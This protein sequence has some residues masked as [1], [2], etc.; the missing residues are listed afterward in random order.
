MF[1]WKWDQGHDIQ[2]FQFPLLLRIDD[3]NHQK[4][5]YEHSSF[6]NANMVLGIQKNNALSLFFQRR[7]MMGI[8]PYVFYKD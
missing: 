5:E 4:Y 2:L 8:S 6:R 3:R 7:Y 1:L